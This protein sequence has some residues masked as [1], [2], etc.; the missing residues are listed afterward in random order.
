MH[1]SLCTLGLAYCEKE[2]YYLSNIRHLK[3]ALNEKFSDTNN[4]WSKQLVHCY[5]VLVLFPLVLSLLIL[6][7]LHVVFIT[8][9]A[10]VFLQ[11]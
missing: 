5:C 10:R 3:L 6:T 11:A 4:S 2:K 7:C 1:I 8:L 9:S